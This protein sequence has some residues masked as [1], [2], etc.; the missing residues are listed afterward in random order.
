MICL[1]NLFLPVA[2]SK[3][4]NTFASRNLKRDLLIKTKNVLNDGE[5]EGDLQ[6]VWKISD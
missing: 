6:E 4:N 3:K 5:K 1:K 2:Y